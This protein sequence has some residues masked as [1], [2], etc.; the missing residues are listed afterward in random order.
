MNI[1]NFING[2]Y[3]NPLSNGWIDNYNP[4]EG[5][6]YGQIPNSSKDDVDNAYE[7]A[8]TAASTKSIFCGVG[9]VSEWGRNSHRVRRNLIARHRKTD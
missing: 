6:V 3:Q 7:A 9:V 5:N 8:N 4:A 2:D 1:Q